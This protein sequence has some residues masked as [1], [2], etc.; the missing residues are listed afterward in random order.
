MSITFSPDGK[1]L[2]ATA[3]DGIQLWDALRGVKTDFLHQPDYYYRLVP[4]QVAFAPNGVHLVTADWGTVR[5]VLRLRRRLRRTGR[6]AGR[7]AGG[8]PQPDCDVVAL[9]SGCLLD[10]TR[11]GRLAGRGGRLPRLFGCAVRWRLGGK[12]DGPGN[13]A[14]SKAPRQRN[15]ARPRIVYASEQVHMSIPKAIALIGIGRNNLRLVP[16]DDAFRMCTDALEA[17][18]AGDRKAGNTPIAI[19]ATAGSVNTGAIDRPPGCCRHRTARGAVAARRRRLRRTG[20]AGGAGKIPGLVAGQF[21]VARRA[22]MA[23]PT[24]R[25]RLPSL[26]RPEDRA[27]RFR[28]AAT[29]S[30]CST[31]TPSRRSRSLTS[32]SSC[33]DAF[34]P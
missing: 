26:S 5:Q 34:V 22:Q 23:V 29:T 19:V 7:V 20:G 11:R 10:R 32:R 27:R 2:A 8:S 24:D 15:S 28:T 1:R 3:S 25:L 17:A 4:S 12:H 33:R 21:P 6:C 18:I 9:G 13:G 14:R 16:V 31:R 30:R